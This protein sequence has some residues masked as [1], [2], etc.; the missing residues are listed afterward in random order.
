M[1]WGV[2]YFT[3]TAVNSTRGTMFL[4][5]SASS[6]SDH[7]RPLG[8]AAPVKAGAEL[9]R[10]QSLFTQWKSEHSVI[11]ASPHESAAAFSNF[12]AHVVML[13][14]ALQRRRIVDV[15]NL[16]DQGR[17]TRF[18]RFA[19]TSLTDWKSAY[20]GT[21]RSASPATCQSKSTV[22][23]PLPPPAA[24]DW[25]TRGV[26]TAVKDQGNC[27]GCWAFSTTGSVESAMAIIPDHG[28][29][30]LS[31]QQLISCDN[32]NYGCA[33]GHADAAMNWLASNGA[34]TE[35]SYPFV[36]SNGD[37]P[38]CTNAG[39]I[40]AVVNVTGCA[41]VPG[42]SSDEIEETLASWLAAYGPMSIY[43]SAMNPLWN[44]YT[45]GVMTGW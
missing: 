43:V 28:L 8:A 24:W 40:K 2:V 1:D 26:V 41:Y 38:R 21:A 37:A 32:T 23:S 36:S 34:A 5:A 45:G 35:A 12:E 42:D 33:G 6:G 22:A 19:A 4:P 9:M 20:G 11:F 27:G 16:D 18:N 10:L 44:T 39:H 15:P 3:F 29:V 17:P 25:R 13:E 14:D 30:S 7:S 31:E